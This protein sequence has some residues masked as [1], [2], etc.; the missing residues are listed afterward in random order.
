[1]VEEGL[2]VAKSDAILLKKVE[3]LTLY[4]LQL[5]ERIRQMES[6]RTESVIDEKP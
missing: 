3:E 5:E 6:V 4:V 1:M 2:D